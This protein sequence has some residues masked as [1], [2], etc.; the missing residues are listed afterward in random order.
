MLSPVKLAAIGYDF[1]RSPHVEVAMGNGIVQ[2]PH[3]T[4]S[5]LNALGQERRDFPALAHA[6]P[7]ASTVDGVLGLDFLRDQKLTL[8]FRLGQ[9]TLE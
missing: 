1:A 2:V 4:L 7:A 9:L 5:R 6:L 3:I 8:D